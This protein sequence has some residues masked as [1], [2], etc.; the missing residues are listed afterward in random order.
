MISTLVE[1]A[2]ELVTQ[3]QLNCTKTPYTVHGGLEAT[4]Q[5]QIQI[6]HIRAVE[7]NKINFIIKSKTLHFGFANKILSE[8]NS[9]HVIENSEKVFVKKKI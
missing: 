8:V 6:A 4:Y 7:F 3:L 5:F 1:L 2:K 9:F